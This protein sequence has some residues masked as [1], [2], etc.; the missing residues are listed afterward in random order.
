[1]R[2]ALL[3]QPQYLTP[4][5]TDLLN[6]TYTSP[7]VRKS[8]AEEVLNVSGTSSYRLGTLAAVASDGTV[9]QVSPSPEAHTV[10]LRA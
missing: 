9:L 5:S 10:D 3:F 6:I 7:F 8:S 4:L 1:M 2:Q